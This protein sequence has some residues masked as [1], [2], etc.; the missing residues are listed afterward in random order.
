MLL[1]TLN[2]INYL[3]QELELYVIYNKYYILYI[4]NIH[5]ILKTCNF[6]F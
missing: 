1:K 3:V 2:N 4:Q 6:T 5:V